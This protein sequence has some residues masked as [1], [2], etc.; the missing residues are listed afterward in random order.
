MEGS[1]SSTNMKASAVA[2]SSFNRCDSATVVHGVKDSV[3]PRGMVIANSLPAIRV[4]L[5]FQHLS[6]LSLELNFSLDTVG[7]HLYGGLIPIR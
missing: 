3:V 5:V 6:E 7:S 4:L 1:Y 2:Q